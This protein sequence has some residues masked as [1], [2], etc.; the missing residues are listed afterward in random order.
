MDLL[1]PSNAEVAF[2][3]ALCHYYKMSLETAI[4][5]FEKAIALNNSHV[6]ANEMLNTAQQLKAKKEMAVEC[7]KL[8]DWAESHRLFSEALEIDPSN[9]SAS[10]ILLYN[11]GLV[12]YRSMNFNEAIIDFNSA[13]CINSFYAKAL[14]WRAKSYF[15]LRMYTKAKEDF[16]LLGALMNDDDLQAH[17]YNTKE[18]IDQWNKNYYFRLGVDDQ[19]SD[20]EII[21]AYR[22]LA[23]K[24]HPDKINVADEQ[25]KKEHE[26]IFKQID[27]AK[28]ALLERD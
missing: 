2:V 23:L 25:L 12:N 20:Q 22:K 10:A 28:K 5:I 27:E 14:K 17:I 26:N 18:A 13:L 19:A 7:F 24:H 21:R 1:H 6:K 15:A 9:T 3:L 4:S 11:R 16:E 8:C